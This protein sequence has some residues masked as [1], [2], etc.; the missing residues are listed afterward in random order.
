M[1][2]ALNGTAGEVYNIA[3]GKET[4]ILELATLINKLTGNQA[5]VEYLPP[6]P[7][8]HSG[9]RFGSTEK[10]QS[11]LG[12]LASTDLRQG[13]EQTIKWTRENMPLILQCMEKH[14]EHLPE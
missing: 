8:D 11:E 4:S 5:G 7:W 2:C 3:S 6:R 14:R 9:K 12:F 1:A 10:A 13:L